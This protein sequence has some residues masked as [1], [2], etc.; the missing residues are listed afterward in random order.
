MD[1]STYVYIILQWRIRVQFGHL[2]FLNFFPV[3]IAEYC[4]WTDLLLFR[5]L[6]MQVLDFHITRFSNLCIY[7]F[8]D[9]QIR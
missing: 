7:R 6:F 5:F 3:H 8:A 9:M 2:E 1:I 4:K